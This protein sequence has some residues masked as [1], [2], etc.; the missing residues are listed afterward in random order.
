MNRSQVVATDPEQILNLTMDSQQSLSLG[1][2]FE[3]TNL[4]FLLP[5][6]LV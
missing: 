5:R 3:S 4:P 2:R 6:M 1:N